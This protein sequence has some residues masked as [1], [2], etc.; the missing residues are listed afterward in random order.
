MTTDNPKVSEPLVSDV[1]ITTLAES[2]ADF[3]MT[4]NDGES[5]STHLSGFE[6][7][8]SS[9]RAIYEAKLARLRAE[10]YDLVGALESMLKTFGELGPLHPRVVSEA[11]EVLSKHKPE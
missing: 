5:Y 8:A 6:Y 11:R 4:K 10:R 9:M 7:G 3:E 2:Y 1:K